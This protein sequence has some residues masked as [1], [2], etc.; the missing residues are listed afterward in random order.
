MDK[1]V[2]SPKSD[3]PFGEVRKDV[4]GSR[5]PETGS[6]YR[7][8]SD[9]TKTEQRECVEKPLSLDAALKDRGQEKVL[10]DY[11]VRAAKSIKPEAS[12]S[13]KAKEQ[14]KQELAETTPLPTETELKKAVFAQVEVMD[15]F[16]LKNA[17]SS[18][19]AGL[20]GAIGAIRDI[21]KAIQ[22]RKDEKQKIERSEIARDKWRIGIGHSNRR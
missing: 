4:S 3:L 12:F 18:M 11:I 1:N 15:P 7:Q 10:T 2:Q 17:S 22:D 9:L 16:A 19:E 13:K 20:A 21:A 5:L 6:P 8:Y 14:L